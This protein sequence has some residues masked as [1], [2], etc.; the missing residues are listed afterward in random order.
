MIISF[1]VISD[2]RPIILIVYFVPEW[3]VKLHNFI[4][5]YIT[6]AKI[7]QMYLVYLVLNTCY[8]YVE[9]VEARRKQNPNAA[10]F[11]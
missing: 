2:C 6:K 1:Y 7:K 4:F 11:I 5:H 9:M 3:I 8:C 10:Y